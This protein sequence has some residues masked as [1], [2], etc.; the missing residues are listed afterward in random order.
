M[1]PAMK[2]AWETV[3]YWPV[4]AEIQEAY[5]HQKQLGFIDN[6]LYDGSRF[7]IDSNSPELRKAF[8]AWWHEI[9]DFT[10]RDQISFPFIVQHFNLPI[11]VLDRWQIHKV[12]LGCTDCLL[13]Y[14]DTQ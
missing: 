7:L 11:R 1:K 2:R 10:F 4:G 9:Q 6:A 5:E 14:D 8:L 12:I 3:D 13:S